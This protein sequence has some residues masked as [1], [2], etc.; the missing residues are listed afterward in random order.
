MKQAF[1]NFFGKPKIM[2]T[3]GEELLFCGIIF[4]GLLLVSAI[5]G[6]I[7]DILEKLKKRRKNNGR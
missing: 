5:M 1:D 4:G 6:L 2:W 3:F 7:L